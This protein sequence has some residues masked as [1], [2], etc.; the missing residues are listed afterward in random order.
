[1]T[2]DKVQTV[3]DYFKATEEH[4]R[5]GVRRCLGHGYTFVDH[6]ADRIVRSDDD[7]RDE[8]AEFKA[9]SNVRYV[10]E[11]AVEAAD[12]SVVVQAVKSGTVNGTFRSMV[13]TGQNVSYPVCDILRFDDDG[14]IVHEEAY[15]DL[16]AVRRQLGHAD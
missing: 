9:W 10:I 4:D 15:Y 6:G 7:L 14:R 5:E 12:G 3:L 2:S 16:L 8:L 11:N 1:M 13:G